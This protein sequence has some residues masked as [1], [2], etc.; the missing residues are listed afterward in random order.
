MVLCPA[1]LSPAKGHTVLLKAV[2]QLLQRGFSVRLLIAGDGPLWADLNALA[3]ELRIEGHT[4]FL[5]MLP[6][7]RLLEL[8]GGGGIDLVVL[9]SLDLGG[10]IHEGIPVSLIE[11]MSFGI[12]VVSTATGG[13]PE[14]LR[15][16]AG[17][18][19][20]PGDVDALAAALAR[21]LE[22]A[23]WRL[24]LGRAGRMRIEG[25]YSARKSVC[26]LLSA[27]RASLVPNALTA[28]RVAVTAERCTHPAVGGGDCQSE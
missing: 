24:Q 22:D 4:E 16:G 14:L 25:D 20:A 9:P 13:I 10:G 18:M 19:V 12:P 17:L 15:D 6:R 5:G 27:I 8:L 11:A 2:A 1:N 26:A 7:E 23:D 3:S 21:L 28:P